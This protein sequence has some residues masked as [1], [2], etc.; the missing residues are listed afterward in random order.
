MFG[1]TLALFSIL[2]SATSFGATCDRNPRVVESDGSIIDIAVYPEQQVLVSF[3]E[4]YLLDL[5]RERPESLRVLTTQVPFKLQF[6]TEDPAYRGIVKVNGASGTTYTLS[7]GSRFQCADTVVSIEK[8]ISAP[9]AGTPSAPQSPISAGAA[10]YG[11]KDKPASLIEYLIRGVV[12]SGYR[13]W[14]APGAPKERE[15]FHQG[16]VNFY[17]VEQFIGS[18]FVGTTLEVVNNGRTPYR[19]AFNQIDF[20]DPAVRKVLGEVYE[21]TMLPGD[22]RLQPAPEF[23]S[24]SFGS[25]NRGLLF[26][27]SEKGSMRGFR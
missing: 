11:S 27:V 4:E 1:R 7:L 25:P 24:G 16:S 17:L 6:E 21:I 3:P 23:V 8:P 2:A 5:H 9:A 14:V 13:R 18:R 19:V 26:I 22:G 15:V 12:P 20:K 10:P